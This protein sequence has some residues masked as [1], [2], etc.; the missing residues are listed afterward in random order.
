[1]SNVEVILDG[2]LIYNGKYQE[3]TY[4]ITQLV[5]GENVNHSVIGNIGYNAG[6]NYAFT[7][8]G[9]GNYI[10]SKTVAWE[11]E[12]LDLSGVVITLTNT[13]FTYNGTAQEILFTLG[14]VEN[15][16]LESTD[17]AVS[18]NIATNAGDY[19]LTITG[20]GKNFKGEATA[21]WTIKRLD[22]SGATITYGDPIIYN[23][24]YQVRDFILGQVAGLDLVRDVDF[25]VEG[26][27][28]KVATNNNIKY[29]ITVTGTGNFIGSIT[30]EWV[31]E[32]KDISGATVTF[33]TNS[34]IYNGKEQEF[35]FTVSD[36]DGLTPIYSVAGNKA[37]NFGEY[38][39]YIVGGGNFKGMI[40]IEWY[41]EQKDISDAE[42]TL[43]DALEY[44]GSEQ[45]R[46]FTA[47]V[48]GLE[49][50]YTVEGD[51]A[52]AAGDYVLT[53]TAN[54]NFTGTLTADW[55]IAKKDISGAEI[56]VDSEHVYNGK[57]QKVKFTVDLDKS[58]YTVTGTTATDAGEY[59][60]V[61]TPVDTDNYTGTIE[62]SWSIAKKS[63]ANAE[64]TLGDKLTYTG[65]EQT[66]N[67][68]KVVVD[69]LEVTFTVSGDKAT[70]VD[71]YVLTIAANGNFDGE[72]TVKYTVAPD[73]TV[74]DGLN[75]KNVNSTNKAAVEAFVA[76]F[77]T[78]T[79]KAEF[80]D[81]FEAAT[82]LLEVINEAADMKATQNITG[83]AAITSANVNA[84]NKTLINAAIRDLEDVEAGK[85]FTADEKAAATAE[86]A[87]LNALLEI[88]ESVA[89]VQDMID[90]LPDASFV[91]PADTSAEAKLNEVKTAYNNLP[92]DKKSVID[93]TKVEA[94]E[95]ALN[96]YKVVAGDEEWT[97]DTNANVTVETNGSSSKLTEVKVDGATVAADKY[98]VKASGIALKAEYLQ[99][100]AAGNHKVTMVY[101]NGSVEFT[102]AV[103][104]A[105]V[106]EE[107]DNTNTNTNTPTTPEEDD[108]GS[109]I[110]WIIAIIGVVGGGA[111]GTV[112]AVVVVRKKKSSK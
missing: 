98:I 82:E 59:V 67:V 96:N 25:V 24:D 97:K 85:N 9:K 49:I 74:I 64:I 92:A 109:A 54:G 107:N 20:A 30:Q 110:V 68:V 94:L 39:L 34:F 2:T 12:K 23:G 19:V 13:D 52:T 58:L 28:G 21:T 72:R 55:S 91:T 80:A 75:I 88:I 5:E 42:I 83:A 22:M 62:M 40:H 51:K 99:T 45:V 111:A 76:L 90:A 102:F 43:G 14:K 1:M 56:T 6:T 61:I 37:T 73:T 104:D 31:I 77:A 87:R 84:A 46:D 106:E 17:Y 47:I 71:A 8:T 3:R 18:G 103:K 53:I 41:I 10:G 105:P 16:I 38:D 4:T 108:N 50:T 101:A 27:S 81:E 29:Y 60:I 65:A 95:A 78:D 35:K 86:I 36:V 57:E 32:Q 15:L 48:D 70:N 79:A 66:Q 63:I 44:N 11:I 26:D 69:G 33:D 89:D 93:L 100:L 7:I 112:A